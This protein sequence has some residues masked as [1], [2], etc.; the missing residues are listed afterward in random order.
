V[1]SDARE[2][3]SDQQLD[4]DIYV[5]G[6]T[7]ESTQL[8]PCPHAQAVAGLGPST[9]DPRGWPDP[10]HENQPLL[11]LSRRAHPDGCFSPT[12]PIVVALPPR[13]ADDLEKQLA[14]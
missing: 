3:A 11:E 8:A 14:D 6:L 9:Y 1:L 12:L 4:A 5:V 13:L 7:F 10:V 2:L